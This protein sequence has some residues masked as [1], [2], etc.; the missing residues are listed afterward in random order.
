MNHAGSF[1]YSNDL[2]VANTIGD[3]LIAGRVE[4]HRPHDP[5]F[6]PLHIPIVINHILENTGRRSQNNN[7]HFGIFGAVAFHNLEVGI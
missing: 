5:Y 6:Q 2:G 7:D 1:Q 4:Q 3:F